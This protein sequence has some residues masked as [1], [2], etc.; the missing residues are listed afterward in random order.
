MNVTSDPLDNFL[1]EKKLWNE[2]YR[3]IMGLDEVGRGCLAGPVAAAGVIFKPNSQNLIDGITDSKLLNEKERNELSEEIKQKAWF[4]IVKLGSP[5]EIEKHNILWASLL[6]MQK[7]VN[8]ANPL[9]EYL[10]VDGNRYLDSII[11]VSCIVKGDRLSASVGAASI[12]AKVYR[13]DLMRKLHR[14]YPYYG[15]DS[16]VGYPTQ[17]HYSGLKKYGYT[18]YHRKN[19][20]LRT[21][22]KFKENK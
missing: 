5:E 21:T 4:W 18:K 19:F 2:G 9:P 10:F 14:E 13:D 3:R 6:T 7:C 11:P 17:K 1:L 12:L 20:K 15:W 22:Q 8:A 16:N